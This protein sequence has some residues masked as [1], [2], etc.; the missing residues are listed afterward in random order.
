MKSL[1]LLR[2]GSTSSGD[3]LGRVEKSIERGGSEVD[4]ID[5]VSPLGSN[6]TANLYKLPVSPRDS[7]QSVTKTDL[8]TD[9]LS[10]DPPLP[11]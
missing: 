5:S 6:S 11:C 1:P 4:K 10:L 8:S 7:L 3:A 2:V 9:P